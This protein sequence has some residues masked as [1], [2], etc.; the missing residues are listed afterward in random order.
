MHGA[1]RC[2]FVAAKKRN[3]KTTKRAPSA[4]RKATKPRKKARRG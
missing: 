4:R 1:G 3:A 2:E